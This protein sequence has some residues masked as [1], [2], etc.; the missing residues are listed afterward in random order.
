MAISS[1]EQLEGFRGRGPVQELYIG[2]RRT[3]RHA[4]RGEPPDQ[5]AG[6]EARRITSMFSITIFSPF[7]IE[8]EKSST[9]AR[10]VN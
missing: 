5:G 4:R 1:I 2:G 3:S 6:G 9:M 10:Q 8:V 7:R